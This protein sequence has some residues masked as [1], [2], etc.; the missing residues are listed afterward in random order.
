MKQK[1]A[2]LILAF[3]TKISLAQNT[4]SIAEFTAIVRQN[5]PVVKLAGINIAK[6]GAEVQIAKGAFNPILS[7]YLGSKT[8]AG[9]SYY[10]EQSPSL[11]IPTWFG[12]DINIGLENLEGSRINP[13]LTTGRSSYVGITIPLAKNLIM[14]KRRA[15]VLQANAFQKMAEAEQAQVVNEILMQAYADYWLWSAAYNIY[16][17]MSKAETVALNRLELVKKAFNNGERP[18]IDTLEAATQYQNIQ[19]QKNESQ[20]EFNNLGL[21][22]ST[23]LWTTA[24]QAYTLSNTVVPLLNDNFA[25]QNIDNELPNLLQLAESQHPSLNIYRVK[26]TFLQIDKKLKFQELLPKAD[27]TY[28]R[29]NKN[30]QPFSTEGL[31]FQNNFQYGLK[32]SMPVWFTAGRGEYS[33]AKLKITENDIAQAQKLNEIQNKVKMY[34]AEY[35]NYKR[36]LTLQEQTLVNFQKL[37]KAEEQLLFNG[38][39]SLFLVNSRENKVLETERKLAEL[40]AKLAKSYYAT[41]WAAG[42]LN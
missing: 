28:N 23:Y 8:F 17:T 11:S 13:E 37:L 27:F 32:F 4:L 14:D 6:T 2:F 35:L 33:K 12:A 18:A 19:F 40:K 10:N 36:Q 21:L 42:I 30:F 24:G 3:W 41:Q 29:L 16:Q 39:S 34:H 31:F 5:H 25:L 15:F 7:N 22:L 26:T 20:L 9:T 38:E 1:W